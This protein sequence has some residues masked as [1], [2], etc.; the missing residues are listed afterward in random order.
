ML[1]LSQKTIET[2]RAHIKRKLG[3]ATN[4]QLI[5]HAIRW[6]EKDMS[7]SVSSPSTSP[8]APES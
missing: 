5:H 4:T 3:A 2:Y 1:H 8:A 6:V 7:A